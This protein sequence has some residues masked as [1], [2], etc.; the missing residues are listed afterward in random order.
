MLL[1][2]LFMDG[3]IEAQLSD[4]ILHRF[5]K[6]EVQAVTQACFLTL[7]CPMLPTGHPHLPAC[8]LAFTAGEFF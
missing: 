5:L 7:L 8:F 1:P 6:E 3:E 4:V 2:A